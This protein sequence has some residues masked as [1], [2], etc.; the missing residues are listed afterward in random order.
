MISVFD[1]SVASYNIGDQN[2]MDAVNEELLHLFHRDYFVRLPVEEI[3]RISRRY[4]RTSDYSFI[5]GTN[6]L[7]NEIKEYNQW[8]LSLH[9][10]LS[11]HICILL[12]CGWWQNEDTMSLVILNGHKTKF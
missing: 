1:A 12:G 3:G 8:D 4:N 7:N 11:I 9:N 10:I 2:I 6:L 5:G